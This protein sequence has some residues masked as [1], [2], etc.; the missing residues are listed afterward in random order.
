MD[1]FF[2][3]GGSFNLC[4][5][6][7]DRVL[8]RYEE[9]NLVLNW[10]KCHFMVDEGIVLGHKILSKGIEVDRTKIEIIKKLPPPTSLKGV[11]GFLGHASFY[12]WF[13]KEFSLIAKPLTILL[14]KDVPFVFNDA[15]LSAFDRLDGIGINTH[16]HTSEL[17]FTIRDNM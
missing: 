8:K 5:A 15:C 13:I 7:L 4:L 3:F 14:T 11:R 9:T 16:N 17:V 1:Y 2:V 10:E 6:N 12:L